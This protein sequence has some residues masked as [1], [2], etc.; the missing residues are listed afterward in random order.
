MIIA[1]IPDIPQ[2]IAAMKENMHI[3]AEYSPETGKF[4]MEG[5]FEQLACAQLMLQ[6]ILKQQQEIQKRQLQR[7][8]ARAYRHQHHGWGGAIMEHGQ[9]GMWGRRPVTHDWTGSNTDPQQHRPAAAVDPSY[10]RSLSYEGTQ[11]LQSCVELIFLTVCSSPICHFLRGLLGQLTTLKLFVFSEFYHPHL[12]TAGTSV[13]FWLLVDFV[14]IKNYTCMCVKW[15]L[16]LIPDLHSGM[17]WALFHTFWSWDIGPY[18]LTFHFLLLVTL[19]NMW[20]QLFS[21]VVLF[22]LACF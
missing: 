10:H 12:T 17:I 2:C 15:V 4:V 22:F 5:S 13:A 7:L 9:E 3:S 11:V 20:K 19:V 8:S 1:S 6:D 14:C 18:I 16:M 21:L